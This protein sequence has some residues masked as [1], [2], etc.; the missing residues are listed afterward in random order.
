M[1]GPPTSISALPISGQG[2]YGS[3]SGEIYYNYVNADEAYVKLGLVNTSPEKNYV[4][5][6]GFAFSN[7]SILGA[8]WEGPGILARDASEVSNGDLQVY[9]SPEKEAWFAIRLKGE[10]LDKI[11]AESLLKKF[12]VFFSK[13]DEIIEKVSVSVSEPSALLLLG[14]GLVCVGMA[15]RRKI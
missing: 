13:D 14:I 3:F 1:V 6:A 9:F 15:A 7:P 5:L 2:S 12:V 4:F 8:S 10:N 11:S